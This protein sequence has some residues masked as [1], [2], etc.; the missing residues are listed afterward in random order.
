M[1]MEPSR[2]LMFTSN[3]KLSI[4]SSCKRD[5]ARGINVMLVVRKS[6]SIMGM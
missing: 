6:S 4:P 5:R 1:P 3:S 2:M